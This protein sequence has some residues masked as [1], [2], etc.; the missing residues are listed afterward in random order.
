MRMRKHMLTV[1]IVAVLVVVGFFGLI[2]LAVTQTPKPM[3]QIVTEL[4][5]LPE[6]ARLR[7]TSEAIAALRR[8]PRPAPDPATLPNALTSRA[9]VYVALRSSG[10]LK[11]SAWAAEHSIIEN[12]R[13]ATAIA[14]D[15]VAPE[16]V[17]AIDAI[18]VCLTYDYKLVAVLTGVRPPDN[19]DAGILGIQLSRGT[20]IRRY[21]PTE[22]LARN[23]SFQKATAEAREA[24]PP[25]ASGP[26]AIKTFAAHQIL[27][28]VA[29]AS[30]V[31]LF[32]GNVLIPFEAVT[33]DSVR[34][35]GNSIAGWMQANSEKDGNFRYKYWPSRGEYSDASNTIRRLL[36]TVA[37]QRWASVANN[38]DLDSLAARNLDATLAS[39]Y[40]LENN[41]GC[42]YDGEAV[43]L[44]AVG[45]ALLAIVESPNRQNFADHEAALKR[46]LDHLW[47]KDTGAFRTFLVPADRNDN[48][49]FYPGEALLAWGALFAESNDAALRDKIMKSFAYYRDWHRKNRNP[50]F[51]PWH[52]QAYALVWQKTRDDALRDFIFE[53]NDWLVTTQQWDNAP[54]PDMKG[55]FYAPDFPGYG[56]PHASSTG[57]YME[58]LVAAHQVATG[59]GDA[60]RAETYRLAMLRGLRSIMQLQFADAVDMYYVSR[61]DIVA[62]GIRTT[63]YNNELRVDNAA[64]NLLAIAGICSQLPADLLP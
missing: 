18:E 63:E 10:E 16:D 43:K 34:A 12:L 1:L 17:D 13:R 28:D 30:S 40:R 33:K 53:M 9:P 41:L 55:R 64:H 4:S 5:T 11:G 26:E 57:V 58:G 46:T 14:L 36:G 39:H 54:Y 49:N 37:V 19:K 32:R 6:D 29:N 38:P 31:Q 60:A 52:T 59:A 22:L 42:I 8:E 35:L 24:L 7:V 15:E 2:R 25:D 61:R 45:L 27:I 3:P 21:A 20:T 23:M 56:P 50:A 48:Q 44:G 62:G 47:N 51:V